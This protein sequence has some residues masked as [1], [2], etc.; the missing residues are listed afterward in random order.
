MS[1]HNLLP[2]R[3]P[4]YP[5]AKTNYKTC[6]GY[7]KKCHKPVLSKPWHNNTRS[8]LCAGCYDLYSQ[9]EADQI[10]LQ[11]QIDD[12][13]SFIS[14]T[15]PELNTDSTIPEDTRA[16]IHFDSEDKPKTNIIEFFYK[17]EQEPKHAMD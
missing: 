1:N 8:K 6:R 15:A 17:K 9:A 10:H 7:E 2:G 13:K 12:D 11:K 16:K 4:V 5:L 14:S 3:T